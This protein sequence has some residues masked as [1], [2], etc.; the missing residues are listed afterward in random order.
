MLGKIASESGARPRGGAPFLFRF[1]DWVLCTAVSCKHLPCSTRGSVG[2]QGGMR[3][4]LDSPLPSSPYYVLF[5]LDA[6]S[7]IGLSMDQ[8]AIEMPIQ[9]FGE[10]QRPARPIVVRFEAGKGRWQAGQ[11]RGI[12]I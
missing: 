8:V 6:Q 7:R 10:T 4:S 2:K 5:V 9:P 3:T 11:A 12:G 1:G